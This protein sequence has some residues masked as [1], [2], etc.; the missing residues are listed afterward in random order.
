MEEEYK[1][2]GKCERKKKYKKTSKFLTRKFL[3]NEY[4]LHTK[5]NP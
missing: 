2:E 3:F 4:L 5:E 1:N